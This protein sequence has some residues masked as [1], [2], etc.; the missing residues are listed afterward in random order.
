MTFGSLTIDLDD[1]SILGSVIFGGDGNDTI[2]SSGRDFGDIIFAGDGD[3]VIHSKVGDETIVAGN[4][5]DT[6][7]V[8][9][10]DGF[11]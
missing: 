6:I 11:F 3:D 5:D 9:S 2:T 1:S 7:I 10:P 4:G 8:S